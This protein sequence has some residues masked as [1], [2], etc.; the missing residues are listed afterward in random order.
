MYVLSEIGIKWKKKAGPF[1]P[2]VVDLGG[3]VPGD[4][5]VVFNLQET[6]MSP[7]FF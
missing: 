4:V 5:T 1:S 7:T 2:S 6:L 3:W